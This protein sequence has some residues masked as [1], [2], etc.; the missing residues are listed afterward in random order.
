MGQ[1][2]LYSPIFAFRSSRIEGPKQSEISWPTDTLPAYPAH[3]YQTRQTN[4]DR[5]KKAKESW[6]LSPPFNPI[7]QFSAI[8]P[9]PNLGSSQVQAPGLPF[10]PQLG[11]LAQ[12]DR[13]NSPKSQVPLPLLPLF[14]PSSRSKHRVKR[15]WKTLSITVSFSLDR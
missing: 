8:S 14:H 2:V 12:T 9:P 11:T 13:A 5:R 4:P 1:V 6:V 3:A 10:S 15:K 7:T